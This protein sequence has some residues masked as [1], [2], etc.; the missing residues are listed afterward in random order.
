RTMLVELTVSRNDAGQRAERY[1]RRRFAGM[2][3]DR[4]HALFRRKEIKISRKPVKRSQLLAQGDLIQVF[5][6]RPED[7]NAGPS[8]SEALSAPENH[9]FSIPILHEDADILVLDKPAGMA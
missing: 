3:L 8:G 9:A 7:V 5:G 1:L 4:L 6:L 2:S